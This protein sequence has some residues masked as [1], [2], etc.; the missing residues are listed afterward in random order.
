MSALYILV[1]VSI[2]VA[3]SFLGAF[4]WSVKTNQYE[5]NQGAAIRMLYDDE[6][7]KNNHK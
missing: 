7:Q 4:I 6:I 1:V 2:C 5:D 3:G